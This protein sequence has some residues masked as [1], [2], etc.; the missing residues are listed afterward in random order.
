MLIAY[1]DQQ[2]G[3]NCSEIIGDLSGVLQKESNLHYLE[4]ASTL[5]AEEGAIAKRALVTQESFETWK[6]LTASGFQGCEAVGE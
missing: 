4:K 3:D 2:M 1:N 5:M 6:H